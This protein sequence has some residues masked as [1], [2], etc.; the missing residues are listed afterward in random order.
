[1]RTSSSWVPVDTCA[2][3]T[4]EQPL[5]LAEFTALFTAS[6]RDVARVGPGHLRLLLDA[7]AGVEDTARALVGREASCC[8][9]F[10]FA[11]A[12]DHRGVTVDVRAPAERT[13]VLDGLQRQAEDARRRR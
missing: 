1:M 10:R 3:P 12:A 2:L 5:R 8:T 4:A 7:G 9:F 11:V 13:G 6:L